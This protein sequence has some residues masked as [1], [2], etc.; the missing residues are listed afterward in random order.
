MKILVTGGSGYVGSVLVPELL[1]AGHSVTVLD[2]L[3]YGQQS[4][5]ACCAF[6][7]FKFNRVDVRYSSAVKPHLH[8]ADIVI[9]LAGLVGAPLCDLNVTDAELVN[10]QSL[11]NLFLMLSKEQRVIFP[12]TESVYGKNEEI[13]TE[14]TPANPLSSYAR[15]KLEVEKALLARGNGI[16]LRPAT[17]F[18]MSPRMRLDLLV[19]DFTWR[20][21][22]D[23]ALVIFEGGFK[24]TMIHVRDLAAAFIHAIDNFDLM[25]G[26]IYNVGSVTITKL[27]LCEE[28]KRQMISGNPVDSDFQWIEVPTGRDQ[29]QRNYVV[30]DEKIRRTGY[31][32]NIDLA[33]GISELLRGY[34]F[35]SNTR[36]GNVP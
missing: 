8:D 15:H 31:T 3:M 21:Y 19:N 10:R 9:P 17:A 27:E 6:D 14:E 12:T 11:L 25:N 2:N 30:S 18:G 28:I 1:K 20:A 16:S 7:G 22:K 24:R 5:A 35:M 23:R 34:R 4:L 33:E 26:E 32:P 13:C 29:D 36:Y